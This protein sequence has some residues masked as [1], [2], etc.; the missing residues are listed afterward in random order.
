MI[1]AIRRG[2]SVA[3]RR[4]YPPDQP[5]GP[6]AAVPRARRPAS[7]KSATSTRSP[8]GIAPTRA[9]T[10][11][12]NSSHAAS[13]SVSCSA[14]SGCGNFCCSSICSS[15]DAKGR[16]SAFCPRSSPRAA[17]IRPLSASE[18]TVAASTCDPLSAPTDERPLRAGVR[19]GAAP[20]PNSRMLRES[21]EGVTP[22]QRGVAAPGA[23]PT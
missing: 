2:N 22:A 5:S 1:S 6:G 20:G 14:L 17:A 10:S 18:H 16:G 15:W 3:A 9:S 12:A 13:S 23:V 7:S 8:S 11:A 19:A 4:R 21:G